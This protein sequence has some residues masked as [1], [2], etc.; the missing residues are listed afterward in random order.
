M[1]LLEGVAANVVELQ[2]RGEFAAAFV[3]PSEIVREGDVGV[4]RGVECEELSGGELGDAFCVRVDADGASPERVGMPVKED[5]RNAELVLAEIIRRG[6]AV[7]DDANRILEFAHLPEVLPEL[8]TA[9]VLL[10]TGRRHAEFEC[11]HIPSE[12]LCGAEN[13][14]KLGLI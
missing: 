5:G 2:R 8:R 14:V 12:R 1:F 4:A 6:A 10:V 3:A 13:A 7:D 11:A 9:V